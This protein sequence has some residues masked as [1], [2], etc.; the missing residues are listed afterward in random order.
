MTG[1][2]LLHLV[3]RRGES[4]EPTIVAQALEDYFKVVEQVDPTAIDE[5]YAVLKLQRRRATWLVRWEIVDRAVTVLTRVALAGTL[6]T[7]AVHLA[8]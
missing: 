4:I 5:R 7:A 3:D 8:G 1:A 2:E 6:V